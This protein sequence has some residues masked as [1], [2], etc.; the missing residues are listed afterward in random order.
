MTDRHLVALIAA[1]LLG[2]AAC[3]EGAASSA[4]SAG[5]ATLFDSTRT[6]TVAART[7]GAVPEAGVRRVVESLRI[8][9]E[10]DD[11]SLF[12]EVS[13]FDVGRDGRLFVFDRAA[14]TLFLFDAAGALQRRIGRQGAGP[15]EFNSNNGM[16]VLSDGRLALWDAQNARISFFSADGD[17][18]KAWVVP[19]GFSSN[20]GL[21]SDAL[22]ALYLVRPVTPP[23]D[24]EI[25]GRMG[26][27]RLGAEGAWTDSLVPPALPAN[28]LVY[29]ASGGGNTSASN[30]RYSPR[31]IWAWHPDGHFVSVSSGTYVIESSR[32]GRALRIERDAAAIAVSDDERALEQETITANLRRNVPDWTWNGPALPDRKPP[33]RGLSVARDGRIW[34]RVATPSELIPEA[35]RESQRPDGPPPARFRE[36]P[37]YEVFTRDGRFLGR[38]A[39][40]LRA[41]FVEAEGD[42]VWYLERDVDGLPAVVRARVEPGFG[43]G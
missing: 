24:T 43:P 20:D 38:V 2:A 32:P 40:P 7:A 41:Q 29:I 42:S 33:V 34:V 6:D 9:P 22:G 8:A 27:V 36:P 3:G 18:E 5:L 1:V 39:L 4:G 19:G 31:F 14:R 26:L 21:R 35:E 17:F 25:L 10:A 23:T 28:A 30:A 11:T 12:A 16:T 13:E 37:V 15:G